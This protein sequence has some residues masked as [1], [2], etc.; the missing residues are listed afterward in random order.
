[1][2]GRHSHIRASPLPGFQSQE[3]T[4]FRGTAGW[5]RV[6]LACKSTRQRFLLCMTQ[7]AKREA[8]CQQKCTEK[9]LLAA[10]GRPCLSLL[11]S[12]CLK[13]RNA[14]EMMRTGMKGNLAVNK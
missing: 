9:A 14:S 11:R 1:M 12:A 4:V 7:R 13:F 5:D 3:E 2:Q 6:D 8:R 10:R